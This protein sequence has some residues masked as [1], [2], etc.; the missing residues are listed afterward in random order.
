MQT[1]THL[2]Y[3]GCAGAKP[4]AAFAVLYRFL[5]WRS[6]EGRKAG[7]CRPTLSVLGKNGGT[8]RRKPAYI[9]S[10]AGDFAFDCARHAD[11]GVR[12][13]LNL[14]SEILVTRGQTKSSIRFLLCQQHEYMHLTH[15]AGRLGIYLVG[16]MKNVLG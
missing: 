9:V 15:A 7:V 5:S 1:F 6:K 13:A 2:K 12:P 10:Y 14:K 8:C 4:R 16:T 3:K 11:C